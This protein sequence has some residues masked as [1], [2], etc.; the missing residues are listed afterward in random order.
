MS[1]KHIDWSEET[2]TSKKM[3]GPIDEV[4]NIR[5]E[6]VKQAAEPGQGDYFSCLDKGVQKS[7]VEYER[8]KVK[9]AGTQL[10]VTREVVG[11]LASLV[12]GGMDVLK[13]NNAI[14]KAKALADERIREMN[15]KTANQLKELEAKMRPISEKYKRIDLILELIQGN[16][17]DPNTQTILIEVIKKL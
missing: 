16:E 10:E 3:V 5:G 7:I 2:V 17:L 8:D 1:L 14:K 9:L 11:I 15:Q 6:V 12:D 4:V 13:T